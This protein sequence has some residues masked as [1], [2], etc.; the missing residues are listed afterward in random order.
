MLISCSEDFTDLAPI[1]NRNEAEFYNTSNDF[2]TAINS[3]YAGLQKDGVYGRSYWTMFEMRSENTDQGPDA[4]GLARQFAEINT[5]QEPLPALHEL[6]M[7]HRFNINH[8]DPKKKFI[9]SMIFLIISYTS[10]KH[11]S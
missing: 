3:S 10:L 5:L 1:S 9:R 7:Q 8:I 2:I 4:T 6:F 11:I